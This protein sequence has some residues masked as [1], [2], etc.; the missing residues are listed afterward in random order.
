MLVFAVE[1]GSITGLVGPDAAGKSTLMRL[2][3]GLLAPDSGRITVLRHDAT[4]PSR[5][6]FRGWSVICRSGSGCMRI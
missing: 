6:L 5:W 2:A 1:K 3:A 4:T